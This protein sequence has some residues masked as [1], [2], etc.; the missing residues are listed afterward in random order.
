MSSRSTE[1]FISRE[2][3]TIIIAASVAFGRKRRKDDAKKRAA[4]TDKTTTTAVRRER[5]PVLA[6]SAVREYEPATG[7]VPESAAAILAYPCDIISLFGRMR[8]LR[9]LTDFA[10]VTPSIQPI[11]AIRMAGTRSNENNDGS[12]NESLIRGNPVGITLTTA[13]LNWVV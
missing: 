6:V 11:N 13:P 2:T 12:M 4:R 7:S 8:L 3:T 10:T 9:P 5:A 1:T